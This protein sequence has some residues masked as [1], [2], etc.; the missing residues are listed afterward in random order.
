MVEH[1]GEHKG[2]GRSARTRGG[3]RGETVRRYSFAVSAV[4]IYLKPLAVNISSS[5]IQRLGSFSTA[6]VYAFAF[7]S[8][9]SFSS[10]LCQSIPWNRG[11]DLGVTRGGSPFL[12][13]SR[14]PPH[15]PANVVSCF[16]VTFLAWDLNY[17]PVERNLELNWFSGSHPRHGFSSCLST[18]AA[19]RRSSNFNTAYTDL[20]EH[21]WRFIFM[22][23][24]LIWF[25]GFKL[26]WVRSGVV[27][28]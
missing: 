18:A 15:P 14:P 17:A 28:F 2:R 1:G 5:F 6:G 16:T 24:V 11:G 25:R 7:H 4:V 12:F 27:W 3:L 9:A 23:M 19:P 13:A 10:R 22:V 26:C 20:R 21:R 8:V